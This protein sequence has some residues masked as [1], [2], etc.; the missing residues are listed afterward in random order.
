MSKKPTIYVSKRCEHCIELLKI[1]RD[2]EDIK[3]NISIVSID[4]EPFPN[5]IK[6]VPSMVDGSNLFNA[7]EIFRMLMESQ[8][9]GG[10]TNNTNNTNTNNTNTN[11]NTNTVNVEKE[12]SEGE[13]SIDGYC[14]NGSCLLFSSLEENDESSSNISIDSFYSTLA[15]SNNNNNSSPGMNGKPPNGSD[16]Y[17]KNKL[18]HMDNEYE[19]LMKERSEINPGASRI[20]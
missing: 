15:D 7:K 18:N 2:R 20:G 17:R 14:S 12:Q 5:Y 1:L 11:T 10:N 8:K 4:D 9:G 6:S 19:R 13:C 16:D 3:G